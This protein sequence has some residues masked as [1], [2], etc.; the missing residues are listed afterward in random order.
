MK[1]GTASLFFILTT[2][3]FGA[4]GQKAETA[5]E[6][7]PATPALPTV[8]QVLDKY[9]TALGGRDNYLKIKSR[10]SSG[11][12]E[13]P[14]MG[15]KGV[16]ESL[17]APELRSYMKMTIAGIG[18][19]I[20]GTDGKTVWAVNPIQGNRTKSGKELAQGLMTA[21]FYKDINLDKLYTK[22]EVVKKDKVNDREV[23]VVRAAKDDLP[24]VTYY[25]D[26]ENG[27][28]VR[29]DSTAISPE[30]ETASSAYYDDYRMV[31]GINVPHKVRLVNPQFQILMLLTSLKTN[32][33]V[34]E[35][36]FA[37]PK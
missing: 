34:D 37:M 19:M 15:I 18:E 8:K 26:V 24:D 4:F 13:I 21:N 14:A 16:F 36:K 1:K 7:S 27:L 23:Y 20:E 10:S 25:F 11:T 6:K 30:G 32:V 3:V 22:V 2:F 28:L 17:E 9:V 5:A 31:D 33:E 12:I 35:A 29:S